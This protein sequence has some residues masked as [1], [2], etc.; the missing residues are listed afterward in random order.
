MVIMKLGQ[1]RVFDGVF[2][3]V[4]I[5]WGR[6]DEYLIIYS[7]ITTLLGISYALRLYLFVVCTGYI[8]WTLSETVM[9][10]SSVVDR[11]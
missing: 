6:R 11:E 9:Y 3:G 7:I 1:M 4:F 10:T 8:V 5:L 2:D